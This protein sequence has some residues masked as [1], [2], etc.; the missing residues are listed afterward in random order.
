MASKEI[1]KGARGS[2][3]VLWFSNNA[4]EVPGN[5]PGQTRT[6]P[7]PSPVP[8]SDLDQQQVLVIGPSYRFPGW[9]YQRV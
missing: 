8:G 4:K 7:D 2:V 9:G 3:W 1:R 6:N 5:S